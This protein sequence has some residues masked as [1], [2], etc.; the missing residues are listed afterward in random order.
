MIDRLVLC[1]P[2]LILKYVKASPDLNTQYNQDLPVQI[3]YPY[4]GPHAIP[5]WLSVVLKDQ[6]T[7]RTSA[8]HSHHPAHIQVHHNP[9][10]GDRSSFGVPHA[11]WNSFHSSLGLHFHDH[12]LTSKNSIGCQILERRILSASSS[13]VALLKLKLRI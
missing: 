12:N 13:S 2:N 7:K 11:I 4:A 1:K 10:A 3:F 5:S 8:K 6:L 9:W